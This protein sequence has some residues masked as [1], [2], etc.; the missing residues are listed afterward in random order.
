M[1]N[2]KEENTVGIAPANIL[3]FLILRKRDAFLEAYRE[4]NRFKFSGASGDLSE[5]RSRLL[6]IYEEVRDMYIKSTGKMSAKDLAEMKEKGLPVDLEELIYHEDSMDL[7]TIKLVWRVISEF[8][9]SKKLT[10]VDMI[11]QIDYHNVEEENSEYGF[12]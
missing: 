11:R 8:L 4:Y 9:Y 6:D 12:G 2:L 5:L 3:R 10:Q 1:I 7:K